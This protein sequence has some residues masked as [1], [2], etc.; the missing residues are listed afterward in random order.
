MIA[1]YTAICSPTANCSNYERSTST[2]GGIGDRVYFEGSHWIIV[3]SQRHNHFSAI[4]EN[5]VISPRAA[6]WR[7]FDRFRTYP[8]VDCKV[9]EVRQV[10][11]IYRVQERYARATRKHDK[12]RAFINKLRMV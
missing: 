7:W 8:R 4:Y 3:D 6:N 1:F 11:P 5:P 12:R 2:A 9:Q 10:L